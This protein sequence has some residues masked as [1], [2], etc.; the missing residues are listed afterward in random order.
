MKIFKEIFAR[1]WAAWGILL[2][3]SSMLFLMIPFIVVSYYK[4]PKKTIGFVKI[5]RIWMHIFLN[6]IFCP[7]TV[8]GKEH[9]M[10]G[11]NYVIVCN[12]NSLMDVPITCPFVPGGNKTIAKAEMA[13]TP[14]FGML[15]RLG[16]VLVDRNS[17]KSRRDSFAKMK[18]VLAMGLHMTIYPEGTRNTTNEPLK[19]FQDGAFRLAIGTGKE[20]IPTLV[21]HTRKVLPADK[22]F[23]LLPHSL[24]MH[25]LPPVSIGENAT[26]SELKQKVFNLMKDYYVTHNPSSPEKP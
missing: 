8:K 22:T 1:I 12:H 10:P 3:I 9:F 7:L 18:R 15:Y 14:V 16:T 20:I 6:G 21:F 23:Y 26:V 17:E 4:E 5:S 13:K 11:K 19:A 2:F 24:Q 25:F